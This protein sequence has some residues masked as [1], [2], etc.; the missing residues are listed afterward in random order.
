MP[1]AW[2]SVEIYEEVLEEMSIGPIPG[3]MFIRIGIRA[4]VQKAK[5]N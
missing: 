1:G 3:R 5:A 2:K 4:L